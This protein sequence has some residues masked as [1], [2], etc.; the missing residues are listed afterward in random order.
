MYPT[1]FCKVLQT[2]QGNNYKNERELRDGTNKREKIGEQ[3]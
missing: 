1:L 2:L 3:K